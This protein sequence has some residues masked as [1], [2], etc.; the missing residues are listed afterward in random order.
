MATAIPCTGST[1]QP[2][3]HRSICTPLIA[4]C[5]CARYQ[6]CGCKCSGLSRARTPAV[7]VSEM[8]SGRRRRLCHPARTQA[9]LVGWPR[10]RPPV[11]ALGGVPPDSACTR[12]PAPRRHGTVGRGKS[13]LHVGNAVPDALTSRRHLRNMLPG[14]TADG[15][16]SRQSDLRSH[17]V[18]AWHRARARTTS[19]SLSLA[20]HKPRGSLA[21]NPREG[22]CAAVL[23]QSSSGQQGQWRVKCGRAPSICSS[24]T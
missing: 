20:P 11:L 16:R 10:L 6:A 17:A 4:Q 3:M 21:T 22:T 18:A 7:K 23:G 15:P 5:V 9:P 8:E 2:T 19:H 24:G 12:Q 13:T 1:R 14:A